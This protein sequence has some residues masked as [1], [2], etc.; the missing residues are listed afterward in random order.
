VARRRS[1]TEPLVLLDYYNFTLAAL[2]A[3]LKRDGYDST[4]PTEVRH[5]FWRQVPNGTYAYMQARSLLLAYAKRIEQE[6]AAIVSKQSVVYWLHVFR[7]LAPTRLLPRM[8]DE[9]VHLVRL[10][11]SFPAWRRWRHSVQRAAAIRSRRSCRQ[12]FSAP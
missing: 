6:I 8:P 3:Q 7:R 2:I 1:S 12:T 9:T 10:G 4:R 11:T 5:W